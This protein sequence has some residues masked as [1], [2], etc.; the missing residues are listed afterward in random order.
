MYVYIYFFSLQWG[1]VNNA[2]VSA[3]PHIS[4]AA[5]VPSISSLAPVVLGAP[6]G[7]SHHDVSRLEVTLL[8]P[9]CVK[10]PLA[11]WPLG[12]PLSNDVPPVFTLGPSPHGS[13][14]LRVGW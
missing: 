6:P 2:M 9:D 10:F 1:L 11:V 3:S 5:C 12:S 7:L 8:P 14:G 13:E 4:G